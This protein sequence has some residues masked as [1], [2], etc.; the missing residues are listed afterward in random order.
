MDASESTAKVVVCDAGPLIHL[1][2][3]GCSELLADFSRVLVPNAVWLEVERHRA[4]ALSGLSVPYIR[5]PCGRSP[6]A[7]LTAI[8][9]LFALDAGEIEA[10]QVAQEQGA[11]LLISDDTAA[12]LAAGQ[13][14]LPVH[15]TIGILL[16]S[17]R[18]G[19]RTREQVIAT[20]RSI[21]TA[22]TLHL[23]QALL[24]E[25]IQTVADSKQP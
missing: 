20:L 14:A 19:R 25:V 17:I 12:R 22:S 9:Q 18:H 16:R 7:E 15:G 11:D 5:T 13:L 24:D 23:K 3:L 1:D 2:E 21:P 10:L 4:S 8:A 6:S